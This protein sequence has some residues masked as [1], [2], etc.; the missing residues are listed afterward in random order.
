MVGELQDDAKFGQMCPGI[1]WVMLGWIPCWKLQVLV[2]P[3]EIGVSFVGM[4]DTV[5]V[6]ASECFSRKSFV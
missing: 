1:A 2:Q 3:T 5:L 4:Q 6:C